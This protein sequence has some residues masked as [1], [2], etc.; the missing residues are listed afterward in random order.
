MISPETERNFARFVE[1]IGVALQ[2]NGVVHSIA[3][4]LEKLA[5][6][7][8]EPKIDT[9][10]CG[11]CGHLIGNW[12]DGHCRIGNDTSRASCCDHTLLKKKVTSVEAWEKKAI[13]LNAYI[14]KLEDEVRTLV[15]GLRQIASGPI[16]SEDVA[17]AKRTLRDAGCTEDRG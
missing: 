14:S 6:Q 2:P 9:G 15:N 12:R 1:I 17:T 16:D 11:T 13:D 5:S 8:P 3:Q 4:S 10:N 7:V